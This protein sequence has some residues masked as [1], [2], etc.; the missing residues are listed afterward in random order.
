MTWISFKDMAQ[1]R[2]QQ[3]GIT[4]K[5]QESLIVDQANYIIGH[6]FGAE[7]HGKAQAI[8]YKNGILTI[9]ILS[10]SLFSEIE[11]QKQ[12]FLIILNNKF[13]EKVVDDLKFLS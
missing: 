9:A 5:L 13:E 3:K 1:D 4:N 8:F 12:E 7:A 6:F 11:S 10:N 2:L